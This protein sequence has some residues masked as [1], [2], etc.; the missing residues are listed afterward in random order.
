[1]LLSKL[2]YKMLGPLNIRNG[3]EIGCDLD[4]IHEVGY[5]VC[6][7]CRD[8]NSLSRILANCIWEDVILLEETPEQT[9]SDIYQ[10]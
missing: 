7:V 8:E 5:L 10:L 4:C 9:R 3:N 6:A 1:M 2:I